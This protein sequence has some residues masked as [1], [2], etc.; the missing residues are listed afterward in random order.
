MNLPK[1]LRETKPSSPE[2]LGEE[3]FEEDEADEE[4]DWTYINSPLKRGR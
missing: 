1:Y 3:E 2:L 4:D